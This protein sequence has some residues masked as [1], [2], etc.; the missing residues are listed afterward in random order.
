MAESAADVGPSQTFLV[1]TTLVLVAAS[2]KSEVPLRISIP[3]SVRHGEEAQKTAT[4]KGW[5]GSRALLLEG[6]GLGWFAFSRPPPQW[7]EASDKD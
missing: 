2:T 5:W 6:L 1:R 3:Y 4:E 7:H